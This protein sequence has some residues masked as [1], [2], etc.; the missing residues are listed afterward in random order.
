M[1][2]GFTDKKNQECIE[3]YKGNHVNIELFKSQIKYITENY[4]VISLNKYIDFCNKGKK[5]PPKSIIITIDDGYKSNYTLAFPILKAFDIPAT[6]FL[7]TDFIE[8]KKF[9]S[10]T[11]TLH[12][13]D[14][15]KIDYQITPNRRYYGLI[16]SN[17]AVSNRIIPNLGV[18]TVW[19]GKTILLANPCIKVDEIPGIFDF[20]LYRTDQS[21]TICYQEQIL[22]RKFV[23]NQG[24]GYKEHN[25]RKDGA[26]IID[27]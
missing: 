10:I 1:Y 21:N 17:E 12:Y 3:N 27:I 23:N 25:L 26:L 15:S 9:L 19:H 20:V 14:Q 2:H 11:D 16:S 22:L 4:N 6:I 5:L 7:T 8:N 24:A 18:V 13:T